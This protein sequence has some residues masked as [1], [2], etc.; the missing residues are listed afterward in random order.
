MRS[1]VIT[2]VSRGLG[3]AL[4]DRLVDQNSR[5]LAIGRRFSPAQLRVAADRPDRVRLHS[6]DLARLDDAALL[7]LRGA[8]AGAVAGAT[9]AVL[10]LNAGVIEP[11]G[12]VG[13]LRGADVAASVAVNLTAPM[14]LTD[15]FLAAR[16]VGLPATVLFISS[17][18]AARV[19][20]GWSVYSAAK[21]GGEMF[22]KVL[23]AEHPDVRAVSVRPGVID[24]GMQETLRGSDFP[25]VGE[26]VDMHG[27]GALP[28]A[29]TVADRIISE[30]LTAQ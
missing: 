16:P 30:H 19:I 25:D 2:G 13:G 22:V 27:R 26:F 11:V 6:V 7:A 3:A 5:V 4:F 9:E 20:R 10:L 29:D 15:A 28:S 24:T 17:G 12:A 18:A 8:C 14:V 21:A 1:V 23:A